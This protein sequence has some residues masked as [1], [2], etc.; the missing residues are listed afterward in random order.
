MTEQVV[1]I[2][3]AGLCLDLDNRSTG[4]LSVLGYA[5]GVAGQTDAAREVLT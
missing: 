4:V 3:F 5:L 1:Q 2:T